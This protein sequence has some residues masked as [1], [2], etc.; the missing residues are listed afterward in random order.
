M[1]ISF[2]SSGSGGD[3]VGGGG[4]KK[5]VDESCKSRSCLTE[6]IVLTSSFGSC[7]DGFY[8]CQTNVGACF[9]L[10]SFFLLKMIEEVIWPA[11]WGT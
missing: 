11:T 6:N 5:T 8:K 3:G 10:S 9:L 2:S 4:V 7:E 1:N